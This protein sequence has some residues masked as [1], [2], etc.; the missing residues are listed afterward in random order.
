[1]VSVKAIA[2]A[3]AAQMTPEAKNY[4]IFLTSDYAEFTSTAAFPFRLI[5]QI[6]SD[7][8]AVVKEFVEK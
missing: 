4:A 7:A 2:L 8:M 1:M 6:P 5:T 3:F